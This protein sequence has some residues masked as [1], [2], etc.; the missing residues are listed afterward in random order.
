MSLDFENKNIL[1]IGG[2]SGIGRG[3]AESFIKYKA[4]VAI[5]GTRSSIEDYDEKISENI[6]KCVYKK[7]DLSSHENLNSLDIPFKIDH[8]ICSQGIVH[9]K[10]KNL[11]WIHLRKL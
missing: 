11:K 2:S 4:N 6:K 5:T 3:I 10:G 8:L 9:I 1:V 7:L